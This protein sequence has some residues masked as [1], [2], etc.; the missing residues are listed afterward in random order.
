MDIGWLGFDGQLSCHDDDDGFHG[1]VE[2]ARS[3]EE[4]RSAFRFEPRVPEILHLLSIHHKGM[5]RYPHLALAVVFRIEGEH[6]W[7]PDHDVVDVAVLLAHGHGMD[8]MPSLTKG[9]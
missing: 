4:F 6:A 9:T 3:G 2:P 8:D 5:F 7:S 1:H